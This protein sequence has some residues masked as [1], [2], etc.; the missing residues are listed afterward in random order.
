MNQV[1]DQLK[2][3]QDE[4]NE[5]EYD[6]HYN[7]N[8]FAGTLLWTIYQDLDEYIEAVKPL[9]VQGNFN[10][11]VG[12]FPGSERNALMDSIYPDDAIDLDLVGNVRTDLIRTGNG[13][14]KIDGKAG[15]DKLNGRGGD[16]I[17][18]GG[19]GADKL[20]G[21]TD[22]TVAP[23]MSGLDRLIAGE[24]VGW[25][26]NPDG[27]TPSG[28]LLEWQNTVQQEWLDGETDYLNGGAGDDYYFVGIDGSAGSWM[29]TRAFFQSG[30][31]FSWNA[32]VLEGLD[33]IEDNTIDTVFITSIYQPPFGNSG[34]DDMQ[35]GLIEFDALQGLTWAP[36]TRGLYQNNGHPAPAPTDPFVYVANTGT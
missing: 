23:Q 9:I 22:G 2:Q 12:P 11:T 24:V 20:Y 7:S 14:D 26:T 34:P 32:S 28:T 5:F 30:D 1:R 35:S 13:N 17:L 21:D 4:G 19:A 29:D 33:V 10:G 36:L 6:G 25:E 8:T 27:P 3:A 15:D 31:G 18:I 16:D